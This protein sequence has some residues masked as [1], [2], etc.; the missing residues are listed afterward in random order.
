MR[1]QENGTNGIPLDV[2]VAYAKVLDVKAVWLVFGEV[3]TSKA[4]AARIPILTG[5]SGQWH[6]PLAVHREVD[7]G[8][9][10]SVEYPDADVEVAVA[11]QVADDSLEPILSFG[12]YV[13]TKSTTETVVEGD[14]VVVHGKFRSE[15]IVALRRVVLEGEDFFLGPVGNH[16]VPRL[17]Y[18]SGEDPEF[19]IDSRVVMA[20]R[21]FRDGPDVGA[22]DRMSVD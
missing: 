10:V 16:E 12:D 13:I 11:Y 18:P 1:N 8:R 4:E 9:Y 14:L 21:R 7:G 22:S 15:R 6:S 2:A 3:D 20:I 5:I 17:P 19:W